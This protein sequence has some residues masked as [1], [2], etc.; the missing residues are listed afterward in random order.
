[1][2]GTFIMNGGT[3]TDNH[4]AGANYGGGGVFVGQDCRFTMS[5]G[6]ISGN[7]AGIGG[8]VYIERWADTFG[9]F[10]LSGGTIS[11]NTALSSASDVKGGGIYCKGNLILGGPVRIDG[12]RAVGTDGT[13]T[14][15]GGGIYIDSSGSSGSSGSLS[16]NRPCSVTINGNKAM[17]SSDGG[18]TASTVAGSSSGGGMYYGGSAAITLPAGFTITNNQ[19]TSAIS[20]AG[21]V[22]MSSSMSSSPITFDPATVWGGNLAVNSS[23]TDGAGFV[24]A[25][26]T[27]NS[28]H[29]IP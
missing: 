26:A 24:G 16:F 28:P 8:G 3:I 15:A 21:G 5:G 10:D 12:N 29:D 22:Y 25:T 11:G 20:R 18:Q 19:V 6:T 27:P 2:G 7:S 13:S 9:T 23:G 1:M 17:Y 4:S 14:A